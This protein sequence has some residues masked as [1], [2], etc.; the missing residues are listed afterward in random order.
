MPW[1]G[2]EPAPQGLKPAFLAEASGTAE[3]HAL[4]KPL[5]MKLALVKTAPCLFLSNL[6]SEFVFASLSW[7]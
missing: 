3:S 2:R 4:P 1:L 7:T 6:G 5:L